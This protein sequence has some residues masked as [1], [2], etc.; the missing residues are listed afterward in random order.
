MSLV[1]MP[2]ARFT[3]RQRSVL[4][5][6][7]GAG[8]MLSVDFSIL[9][10]ALPD[11][12]AGVGLELERLPWVTTAFVLPAAGFTLVSGRLADMV[13]RRRMFRFGMALL[14][15]ASLLGGLATT[16]PVLSYATTV[17]FAESAT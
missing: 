15:A 5:L 16:A 12:G 7:L 3:G 2:P 8:F 14:L 10:V 13:G 1:A 17:S 11:I 6:L 4:L 9:T